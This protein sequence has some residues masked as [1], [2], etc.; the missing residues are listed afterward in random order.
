MILFSEHTLRRLRRDGRPI[1][2][3]TSVPMKGKRNHVA[4]YA[5]ETTEALEPTGARS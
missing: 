2:G 1:V 5:L 3:R 4:L